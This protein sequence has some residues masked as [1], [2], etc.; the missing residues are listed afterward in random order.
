MSEKA[1]VADR[2][3]TK[4]LEMFPDD[5]KYFEGYMSGKLHMMGMTMDDLLTTNDLSP[6]HQQAG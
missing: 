2:V 1:E 6:D 3:M 5:K 4:F